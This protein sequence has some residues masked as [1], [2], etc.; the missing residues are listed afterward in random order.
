MDDS[1]DNL[2][3]LLTEMQLELIRREW[4]ENIYARIAAAD[5]FR[6]RM[7]DAILAYRDQYPSF[8]VTP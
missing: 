2:T 7:F 1:F 4:S 8:K 6:G 3:K 5:A